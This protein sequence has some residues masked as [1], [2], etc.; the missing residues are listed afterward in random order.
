MRIIYNSKE[1]YFDGGGFPVFN[2]KWDY[3]LFR[4]DFSGTESVYFNRN[5]ID[6]LLKRINSQEILIHNNYS[7][8]FAKNKE[9]L[10]MLDLPCY[11]MEAE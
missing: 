7:I 4:Q 2:K 6:E 1:K 5:E 8:L 9:L 11:S 3:L 10:K